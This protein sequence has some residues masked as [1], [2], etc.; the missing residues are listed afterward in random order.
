VSPSLPF[1]ANV[2]FKYIGEKT[3]NVTGFGVQTYGDAY[4]V[5]A[6]A[7]V[8]LDRDQRHR[9]TLRLENL[10]DEEYATAINS[11]IEVGS[12]PQQRFLWQRL[13]APRTVHLNYSY[14]F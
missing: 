6:G 2:A 4:V 9:V 5:D 8:Y 14:T 1:G 10:L 12:N 3:N 11:A 7:H 13:G